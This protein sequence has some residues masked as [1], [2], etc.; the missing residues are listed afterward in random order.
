MSVF[1]YKA[2]AFGGGESSSSSDDDVS[3]GEFEREL[4]RLSSGQCAAEPRDL[5]RDGENETR[6]E[7]C[8]IKSSAPP[9]ALRL[10]MKVA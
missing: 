8:R 10:A 2:K 7:A 1:Q 9:E 4:E 5:N 6:A 3:D